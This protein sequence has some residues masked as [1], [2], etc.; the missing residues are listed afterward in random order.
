[1]T[2]SNFDLMPLGEHFYFNFNFNFNTDIIF[3]PEGNIY[4]LKHH[5]V[6]GEKSTKYINLNIKIDFFKI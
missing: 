5:D 4:L 2:Y 3:L 6:L 1:M